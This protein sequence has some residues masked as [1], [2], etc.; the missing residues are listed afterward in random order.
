[1]SFTVPFA[2][3]HHILHPSI[4]YGADGGCADPPHLHCRSGP[5]WGPKRPAVKM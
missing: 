5:M 1:M 2:I 3:I 4:V